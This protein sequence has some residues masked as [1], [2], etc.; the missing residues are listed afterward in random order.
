MFVFYMAV[1][2]PTISMSSRSFVTVIF[3]LFASSSLFAQS[4]RPEFEE[5]DFGHWG[6]APLHTLSE[7]K[8]ALP[9]A[10][11]WDAAIAKRGNNPDGWTVR[12]FASEGDDLYIGGD[13]RYFDTVAADFIVHYNRK[14]G[15]WSALDNGLHNT[16][17]SLALHNGKLYAGGNFYTAGT[18][19]DTVSNIAMWD[20]TKWHD[21][22]GGVNGRV[23]ALAFIG[24]TLYAGGNFTQAG[25]NTASFLAYWDGQQ[26]A[27]A[28]GGTSYP[29]QAL[30]ATHDS[31]FVGGLFNYVGSGTSNTGLVANGTAMLRDGAWSAFG[32][33]FWTS[34]L[35]I[36]K[37]KLWAGGDYFGTPDNKLVNCIGYWDGSNWNSIGTDTMVGTNATGG[38]YKLLTVGDSLLALGNFSMMAGVNANGVAMLHNDAWSQVAGGVYGAAYSGNAFDGKLYVGGRFTKVGNTDAN[39]IAELSPSGTW[40]AVARMI[41]SYIGWESDLV[42]AIATTNRYV[43][44]GGHFTTIAGQTCNHVAAWDKQTKKWITLGLGVDGDVQALAVQGNNLIV[45]GDFAHAGNIAARNI[46]MCNI[47]TKLWSAMGAGSHRTVWAIATDDTAVYASVYNV[48]QNDQW[49]DY[50]GKWDGTRWTVFGNGLNAG[51]ITALVRQGPTLFAAG[52]FR[53]TD[54]GTQVNRIAQLQGGNSWGALNSGLSNDAYALAV[55]GNNLFV[56]GSF[57]KADGINSPGLAEWDGTNWNPIGLGF[58]GSVYAL[59]SDGMGGVYAGG[60]FTSVAGAGRGHL[61]H[62][63]GTQYGTVASGVSDDVLAIATDTGSLYAGGWFEVAGPS[64]TITLH[65]A[66]LHGA[67]AA[68]EITT[69]PV[70]GLSIFPNPISSASTISLSLDQSA[71]VRL[72]LFNALGERMAMILDKKLAVGPQ[73]FKLDPGTLPNGLYFL[74]MTA[75]GVV[76]AQAVQ[77]DR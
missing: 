22:D 7:L 1:L 66:Q 63:D 26:W 50:V 3:I 17:Y 37:G 39:A 61:V 24:D 2:Q 73:E 16:V 46:A 30:L 56:G 29:V 62:W 75:N 21:L 76:S 54:E 19:P 70:S 25:G 69:S 31:L 32:N 41:N 45:G 28:F 15:V 4:R 48:L 35:A 47:T 36:Y 6:D 52:T 72:E 10:Q 34:T 20:G 38:V 42:R 51:S 64:Q 44:I 23:D 14:T 77:I 13:F 27:E 12:C 9:E 71:D 49:F 8:G 11:T 65:F 33:G 74:R 55:S 53:L 67:G 60:G 18:R 5:R 68:V 43:F 40:S 57:A 58:N 59:T